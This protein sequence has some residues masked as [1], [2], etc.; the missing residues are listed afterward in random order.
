MNFVEKHGFFSQ[1][2]Q[3]LLPY[4]CVIQSVKQKLELFHLFLLGLA[5]NAEVCLFSAHSHLAHRIATHL[6]L[7]QQT[8]ELSSL[9]FPVIIRNF[10]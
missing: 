6:N 10:G 8:S 4:C 2:Q 5:P 1:F 9:V 7:L 3:N